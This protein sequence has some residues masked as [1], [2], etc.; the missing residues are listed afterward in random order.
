MNDPYHSPGEWP[1]LRRKVSLSQCP[2]W[3]WGKDFEVMDNNDEGRG[4]K[5]R[6]T[7]ILSNIRELLFLIMSRYGY[8]YHQPW[9][10]WETGVSQ[11]IARG[12]W[13]S[14][15]PSRKGQWKTGR[16]ERRWK[17]LGSKSE[18]RPNLLSSSPV[19]PISQVFH[20]FCFRV[21]M[22]HEYSS[23]KGVGSGICLHFS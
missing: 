18:R 19:Q 20:Q 7:I 9:K 14:L 15:M 10:D 5:I 12:P 16:L 4:Y 21:T 11:H 3:K 8:P 13:Q 2:L 6:K 17:P 23:H 1:G 22:C